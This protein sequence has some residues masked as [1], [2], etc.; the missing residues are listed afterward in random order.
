MS[1]KPKPPA[2]MP[3]PPKGVPFGYCIISQPGFLDAGRKR[4]GDQVWSGHNWEF[5]TGL[6][7][8]FDATRY[9]I[10]RIAK[11]LKRRKAQPKGYGCPPTC[12]PP[13]QVQPVT[14]PSTNRKSRIVQP[15]TKAE[16][17]EWRDWREKQAFLAAR[18]NITWN[19]AGEAF[20]AGWKAALEYVRKNP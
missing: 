3:K 19:G 15:V 11:P 12:K 1:T 5:A 20:E 9:Y 16:V 8:P 13:L 14:N 17:K 6:G 4:A 7:E 18:D 10:R 2:T